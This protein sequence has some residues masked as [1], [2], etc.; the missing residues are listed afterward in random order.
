M[1]AKVVLSDVAYQSKAIIN[2]KIHSQMAQREFLQVC[3]TGGLRKRIARISNPISHRS[4]L[5]SCS[6]Q[7]VGMW[8][9]KSAFSEEEEAIAADSV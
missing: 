6:F 5:K 4:V 8:L 7:M 9:D 3:V 1:E 2:I